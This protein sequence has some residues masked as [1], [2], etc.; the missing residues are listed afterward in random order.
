MVA[1]PY[2]EKTLESANEILGSDH[3]VTGMAHMNL[4][5]TLSKLGQVQDAEHHYRKAYRI[6]VESNGFLRPRATNNLALFLQRTDRLYESIQY[7][8]E[9]VDIGKVSQGENSGSYITQAWGI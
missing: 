7:M 6:A 9:A 8:R 4:A 3:Q 2:A 5:G 1:L